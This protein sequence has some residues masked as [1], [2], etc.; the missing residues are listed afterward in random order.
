MNDDS[1]QAFDLHDVD[2]RTTKIRQFHQLAISCASDLHH[3]I[4]PTT[5]GVPWE[6]DDQRLGVGLREPVIDRPS[7][8]ASR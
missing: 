4:N 3:G 8:A 1:A 2:P 5:D 7:R 6:S